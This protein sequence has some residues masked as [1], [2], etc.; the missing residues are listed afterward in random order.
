MEESPTEGSKSKLIIVSVIVI[1]LVIASIG[2]YLIGGGASGITAMEGKEI[3]DEIAL[4]WN[5]SAVLVGGGGSNEILNDGRATCWQFSYH[6]DLRGNGTYEFRVWVYTDG[7]NK[8]E[9]IRLNAPTNVNAIVNWSLDSDSIMNIAL[10]NSEINS[11][12]KHNPTIDMFIIKGG[13][14]TS[15]WSIY[16][17][18]NAGFDDPKWAQIQIDANTGEILYVDADN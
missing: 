8:A 5:A 15:I 6:N 9:E 13:A 1:I 10:Q 4:A 17:V 18:Y 11:F 2:I 16:W 14:D 7:S 3:A 12:M